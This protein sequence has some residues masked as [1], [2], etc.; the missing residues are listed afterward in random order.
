MN[1]LAKKEK[2]SRD[3]SRM[4]TSLRD[5]VSACEIYKP[6]SREVS[7]KVHKLRERYN[8]PG[9]YWHEVDGYMRAVRERWDRY[10]LI[11]AS[12]INGELVSMKWNDMTEGQRQYC[13]DGK[14]KVG[15]IW[16]KDENGKPKVGHPYH[17]SMNISTEASQHD[18]SRVARHSRTNV[19]MFVSITD[20]YK[21][22]KVHLE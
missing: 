17:V 9:Y 8:L 11:H 14:D 13:R 4:F 18:P 1:E 2:R 3:A 15:G 21:T 6:T 22:K 10:N 5:I 19:P 16:W 7:E 20:D 12:I